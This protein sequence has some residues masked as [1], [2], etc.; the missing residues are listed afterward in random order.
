MPMQLEEF[1]LRFVENMT[2]NYANETK[3]MIARLV[4]PQERIEYHKFRRTIDRHF[5]EEIPQ[6][7]DNLQKGV[8]LDCEYCS[9]RSKLVEKRKKNKKKDDDNE[10]QTK[11]VKKNRQRTHYRCE[12]CK[13]ACPGSCFKSYLTYIN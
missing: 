1:R 4:H 13:V 10:I 11:K 7:P 9:D 6:D 8:R 2:K 12:Q 5:L 3:E